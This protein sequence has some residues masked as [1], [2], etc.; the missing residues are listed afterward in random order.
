VL[1]QGRAGG[2]QRSVSSQTLWL[3]L[4]DGRWSLLD[5]FTAS[6]TRYIVAYENPPGVTLRAL[7]LQERIV[8]NFALAGR[9]GKWIA[10][11]LQVSESTVARVLR[12]ALRRIGAAD[13]AT[14][15][16]VPTAPFELLEG[17]NVS[18]GLAMARLAPVAA[19][20]GSLTDAEQAIVAGIV[21]GKRIA[22]IAHERGTSPRTV[23]HQITSIYKKLGAS[24]RREVLALL[25]DM[26]RSA[27]GQLGCRIQARRA[28]GAW[29]GGQR[30]PHGLVGAR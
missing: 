10:Y 14:L 17:V 19:P 5:A 7:P 21:D 18:V 15:V 26:H 24:S 12:T 6:G 3:A 2:A 1:A 22:T 20:P 13:T 29:A 8:L 25:S 16:G 9:S 4:L 30:V 23:S 11:E 27:G 28:S